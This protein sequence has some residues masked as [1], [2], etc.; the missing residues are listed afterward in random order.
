MITSGS[1]VKT[2]TGEIGV[3]INPPSGGPFAYHE[4]GQ[5]RMN[6]AVY[7]VLLDSGEVRHYER[8]ALELAE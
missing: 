1:T 5:A 6:I 8:S 3:V 4:A 2:P 7:A